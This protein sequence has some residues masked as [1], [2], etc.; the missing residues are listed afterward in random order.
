MKKYRALSLL[1][2]LGLSILLI[3]SISFSAEKKALESE[4]K[5]ALESKIKEEVMS[6]DEMDGIFK[7]YLAIRELLSKDK[8][9]KVEFHAKEMS[10]QLDKLIGALE[11]IKT[12]SSNLKTDNVEEA[13]KGFA[14]LSQSVLSYLKQYSYS[15]ETYGFYCSM[16]KE[17]WLQEHDQIG[18]PYYGS[19][20]YKCGEMAGMTV[21]GKYVEKTESKSESSMQMKGMGGK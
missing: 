10:S 17:S 9:E 1:I 3:F 11:S 14:A 2:T 4:I 13:R 5:K 8:V 20:M 19:K 15:D 12:S 6:K 7:H 16:V 21:M 18:N